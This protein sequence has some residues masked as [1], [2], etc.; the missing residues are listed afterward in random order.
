MK[1]CDVRSPNQRR[2]SSFA[3]LNIKLYSNIEVLLQKNK[4]STENA[5]LMGVFFILGITLT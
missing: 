3:F 5:Y 2:L 1:S 4:F